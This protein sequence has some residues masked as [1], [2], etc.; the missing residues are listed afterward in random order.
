MQQTVVGIRYCQR[1]K[2]PEVTS[3][4]IEV[5]TGWLI[6]VVVTDQDYMQKPIFIFSKDPQEEVGLGYIWYEM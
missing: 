3:W 5:V 4:L 2:R 1:H 6:E